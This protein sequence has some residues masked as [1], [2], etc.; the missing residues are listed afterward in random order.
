METP[1]ETSISTPEVDFNE[2]TLLEV[3]GRG[4]FG[5]V[6]KALWKGTVVAVKQIITEQEI[7]SFL[8]EVKQLSRLN[9]PN[10]V[11]LHCASTKKPVC[12]VME[13]ADGGSLHEA[14]HMSPEFEYSLIHA[15]NWCLQCASGVAYL[16]SLKPKPIVHRDLKTP[17]LLLFNEGTVVKICDLGTAC[18]IATNM[19]SNRGTVAWMAPEVFE[20]R[21]YTEKCDVYSWGVILWQVLSR[22]IP[23]ENM[24]S[25]QI[26]WAVHVGQ[27]PPLLKNCPKPIELLI[28]RCW[29]KDPKMRPSIAEVVDKM[30]LILEIFD[31]DQRKPT[32][33]RMI[34]N[35]LSF[36]CKENRLNSFT[37]ETLTNCQSDAYSYL[38]DYS[39]HQ[40]N[41]PHLI[42]TEPPLLNLVTNSKLYSGR[43]VENSLPLFNNYQVMHYS[44]TRQ[45]VQNSYKQIQVR[46][47]KRS[48]SDSGS[49]LNVPCDNLNMTKTKS[50]NNIDDTNYSESLSKNSTDSDISLENENAFMLFEPEIRPVPPDITS[51]ESVKIFEEHRRMCNSYLEKHVEMHLLLERKKKAESTSL[52][53]QTH[54]SY[55]DELERLTSEKEEL[56]KFKNNLKQQ[57]ALIRGRKKIERTEKPNDWVF[58]EKSYK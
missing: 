34:R 24:T 9:H 30:Q 48:G 14:L 37:L 33:L 5:V 25:Y 18:D 49:N 44:S 2:I 57:L 35:G 58:V 50:V 6:K 19:T 1:P 22:Q 4:S 27:R 51:E 53:L 20:S 17:N 55:Y 7:A 15:I 38:T 16:H 23:Y 26:M 21:N 10:I 47:H 8:T 45:S 46:G 52:A 11:K 54:V 56:I 40:T 36:I 31:E 3:V 32:P 13:F 41:I 39:G 43:N 28:T 29:D 12:L 42:S